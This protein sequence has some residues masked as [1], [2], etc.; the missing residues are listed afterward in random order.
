MQIRLKQFINNQ[1]IAVIHHYLNALN[2][3]KMVVKADI[4]YCLKILIQKIYRW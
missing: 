1:N 4:I 2:V 3:Q